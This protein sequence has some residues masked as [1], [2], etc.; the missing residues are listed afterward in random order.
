MKKI[1]MCLSLILS[2]NLQA[3]KAELLILDDNIDTS[4]LNK[5]FNIKRGSTLKSFL[6]DKD[7]RDAF[8]QEVPESKDWDEYQ[9]DSFYM[10]I[11]NKSVKDIK[12]KY[13]HIS[14]ERITALKELL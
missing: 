4:S 14:R 13:P 6:P 12:K 3:Q 9:K 2:L 10:D 5:N 1:L 11:K 7:E 8:L